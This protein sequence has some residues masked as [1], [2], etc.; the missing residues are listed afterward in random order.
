M[1]IKTNLQRNHATDPNKQEQGS[2]IDI[3]DEISI[4]VRRLNSDASRKARQEA[5]KPYTSQLREKNPPADILEKVFV[6]QL[7]RGVIADWKGIQDEEGNEI[8]YSGDVAVELLSDEGLA[9][10]RS[11]IL[12]A[13]MDK[14]TFKL[15]ADKAAL[16][17]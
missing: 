4:K 11:E 6:E 3:D 14:K 8:P 10:F 7:A 12:Q 13:A 16:G 1:A 17:N 9:D 5:E 15:E 2:W